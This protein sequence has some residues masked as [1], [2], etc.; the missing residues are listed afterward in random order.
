[1]SGEALIPCQLFSRSCRLHEACE[2]VFWLPDPPTNRA[3][4]SLFLGQWLM[5]RSS[6]V[7]AARLRRTL[8]VLPKYPRPMGS[9]RPRRAA[10][11]APG[12]EVWSRSRLRL[13][14]SPKGGRQSISRRLLSMYPEILLHCCLPGGVGGSQRAVLTCRAAARII[15]P[16]GISGPGG[17]RKTSSA[18][19]V[20]GIRRLPRRG[21]RREN[22]FGYAF[23]R[24]GPCSRHSQSEGRGG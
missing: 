3:F 8:T 2:Q 5:R 24:H 11:L 4:P 13:Q 16:S 15:R 18:G 23:S 12:T 1:M 6:P 10:H 22:E 20:P 9:L 7:T 14:Y 21:T 17:A 19:P